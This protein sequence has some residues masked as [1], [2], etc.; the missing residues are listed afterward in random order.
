M[1]SK[2]GTFFILIAVIILGLAWGPMKDSKSDGKSSSFSTQKTSI[3]NPGESDPSRS[4]YADKIDVSSISN[5]NPEDPN[6]EV[7]TLY[8]NLD[9]EERLSITGWYFKSEMTGNQAVIGKAALLPFLNKGTESEVV[10][11][12]GDTVY[13]S[14]GYSPIGVSF[15]TNICTGYFNENR[16]FYPMLPMVCPQAIEEN[17]PRFSSHEDSQEACLDAIANVPL[18]STRGSSY[19]RYLP[20]YVP[21]ACKKYIETQIN[22]D[23][24]VARHYND[25]DFAGNEY[26]LYF[27]SFAKL[28]RDYN[29]KEVIRLYD[30]NGLIVDT[31]SY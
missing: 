19:T 22:Y 27:K 21:S 25:K 24:C 2:D 16:K 13:L 31:I 8:V 9:E 1:K 11:K 5:I 7:I 4:P 29:K 26:Y 6:D 28:W 23:T 10:L 20:D 3:E 18:C 14:K 17:I 15:R 30:N 12:R